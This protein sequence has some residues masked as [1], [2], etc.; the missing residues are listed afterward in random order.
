MFQKLGKDDRKESFER[1]G[2]TLKKVGEKASPQGKEKYEKG[3]QPRDIDPT[4]IQSVLQ[5]KGTSSD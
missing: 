4:E 5:K 1:R 3:A 2:E